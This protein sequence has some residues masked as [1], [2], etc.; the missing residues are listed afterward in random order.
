MNDCNNPIHHPDGCACPHCYCCEKCTNTDAHD[1]AV[2]REAL[3]ETP[4][5]ICMEER[6]MGNGGCGACALCCKELREALELW[7][8]FPKGH[9]T[10]HHCVECAEIAAKAMEATDKAIGAPP[11]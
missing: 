4:T 8:R 3:M 10:L 7:Q 5:E 1:K 2:K 6:A 11:L 9:V